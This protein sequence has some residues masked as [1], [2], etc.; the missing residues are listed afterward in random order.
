MSQVR[1][2]N[3]R[4][5]LLVRSLLHRL[6]FRF[7]LHRKDLPGTPDI[8]LPRYRVAIFV[9][10][11]F[12]H[13]HSCNRGHLPKTNTKFWKHKVQANRI[14][15]N[16][17]IQELEELGWRTITVWGCQTSSALKLNE[18]ASELMRTIGPVG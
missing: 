5:E 8:V 7:R 18:L 16:A 13:G 12:W 14:R 10:G 1:N 3:T 4:P 2:R 15:D 6:G 17:N 9:N 11:C